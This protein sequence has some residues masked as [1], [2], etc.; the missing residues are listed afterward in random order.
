MAKWNKLIITDAGYQ[1]SAQTLAEQKIQYTHVQT[2][3]KDMS[4]MTNDQLKALTKL[5]SVVQDLPVGTISVQDDHTVNVP[6]KVINQDLTTDYLLYG[7]ALYAKPADGDE[8]LYGILTA[9]KPDLIPAQTGATVTGTNFKLKVHV[10]DAANVN[11]VISPDGSVSNDE[12]DGI[13]KN[14]ILGTDLD[15]R[16]KD[17]YT[18]EEVDNAIKNSTPDLPS[19]LVSL[20]DDNTTVTATTKD[21]VQTG[22]WVT[23]AKLDSL[24][25][26]AE[27]VKKNPDTGEVT[28]PVNFGATNPINHAGDMYLGAH[29]SADEDTAVAAAKAATMP[30]FF[31]FPEE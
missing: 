16:F 1:L 22:V 5:D 28:E 27:V 7:L 19:G 14:Y 15:E 2:T 13:L 18:K 12:L 11:I 10:G 26:D 9:S 4:A 30:G 23:Q 8:I 29:Q 6:V 20:S 17:Y 25:K 21:G 3:D 24:A 31:W